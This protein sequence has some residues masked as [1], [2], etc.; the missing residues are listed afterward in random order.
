MT[1]DTFEPRVQK[2]EP[3]RILIVEDD[4]SMADNEKIRA[5]LGEP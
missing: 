3:V 4:E 1:A 5:V 2:S